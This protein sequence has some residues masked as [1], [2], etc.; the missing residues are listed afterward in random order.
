MT[1]KDLPAKA[2]SSSW[3]A[4]RLVRVGD[5]KEQAEFLRDAPKYFAA[6]NK[7]AVEAQGKDYPFTKCLVSDETFG[8]DMGEAVDVVVAGRLMRLCCKSC[9]KGIE[10]E[11]SKFVSQVDDGRKKGAKP[12]PKDGKK[13]GG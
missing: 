7:A 10:K 4:N 1:G 5:D 8:G 6:L 9:L 11:P 13:G 3:S 12:E 2:P